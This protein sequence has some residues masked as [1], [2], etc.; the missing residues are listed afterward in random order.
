MNTQNR[1]RTV[2][3][4]GL[5]QMG[6]PMAENV[7]KKEHPLVA[8]DIDRDKLDHFVALGAGAASN[9]ADVA[10]RASTVISMVDTTAQA[11][12]VIL[13]GGGLQQRRLQVRPTH[14]HAA[15]NV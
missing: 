3:F 6:G 1:K 14:V 12:Q 7:M 8:Y 10:R 2:G 9:P 4:V 5:G 15:E 11:E 13:G